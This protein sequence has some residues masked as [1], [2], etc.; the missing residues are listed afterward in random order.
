MVLKQKILK[1]KDELC[2]HELPW[3]LASDLREHIDVVVNDLD[4]YKNNSDFCTDRLVASV[5]KVTNRMP[6]IGQRLLGLF[7][8][9]PMIPADVFVNL[10]NSIYRVPNHGI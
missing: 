6:T 5:Y 1:L 3:Y 7:L 2:A 9:H 10:F 8:A 4:A